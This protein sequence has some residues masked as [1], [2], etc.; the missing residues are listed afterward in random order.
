MCK[1]P[2]EEE[3]SAHPENWAHGVGEGADSEP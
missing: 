2:G 3:G 1:G